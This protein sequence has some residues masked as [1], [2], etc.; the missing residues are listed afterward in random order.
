[1]KDGE[2]VQRSF[3][4][5]L[6]FLKKE[7]LFLLNFWGFWGLVIKSEIGTILHYSEKNKHLTPILTP[8]P[9]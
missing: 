5:N 2:K 6:H 8:G 1:M 7:K 3:D 9:C 4:Y